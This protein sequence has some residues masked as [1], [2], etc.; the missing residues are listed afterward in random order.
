MRRLKRQKKIDLL[1]ALKVQWGSKRSQKA[2]V[3]TTGE[4]K[5]NQPDSSDKK[6]NEQ[7]T[8]AS[9]NLLADPTASTKTTTSAEM[10][11]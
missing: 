9:A 7:E 10:K 4:A 8:G 3:G 5:S 1:R 11:K 2:V 6:R